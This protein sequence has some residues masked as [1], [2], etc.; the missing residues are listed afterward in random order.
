M[1]AATKTE[2][3]LGST[4]PG[5]IVIDE[6]L[7]MLITLAWLPLSLTGVLVGFVLFRVYDVVKPYPAPPFRGHARRLGRDGWTM[8]WRGSTDKPPC[9]ARLGV[10][11]VDGGMSDALKAVI[12]AVGSE[13][14]TPTKTDTNSLFITETLNGLGI[15]VAYKAV[16]GD[17]RQELGAAGRSRPRTSPHPD[18]DRWSWADRRRHDARGGRRSTWFADERRRLRLSKPFARAFPSAV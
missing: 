18:S 8:R 9:A 12:I 2:T 10:A 14:L 16:V 1:W 11:G 13:M 7:G 4:D 17:D 5:P 15:E 3:L 6:V